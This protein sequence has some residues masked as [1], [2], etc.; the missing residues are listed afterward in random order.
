MVSKVINQVV[1]EIRDTLLTLVLTVTS[2]GD[3]CLEPVSV[4]HSFVTPVSLG[5]RHQ[6]LKDQFK[7]RI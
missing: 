3:C 5:S 4:A 6:N 7:L 1:D 2:E